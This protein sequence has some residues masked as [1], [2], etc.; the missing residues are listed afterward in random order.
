MTTKVLQVF[1]KKD[2]RATYTVEIHGHGYTLALLRTLF[3]ALERHEALH[4]DLLVTFPVVREL[5][6][7]KLMAELD[8][9]LSDLKSGKAKTIPWADVKAELAAASTRKSKAAATAKPRRSR[10][11]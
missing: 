1:A 2:K 4:E 6:D 5:E 8:R 10:R 9:R 7:P 11:T 3:A